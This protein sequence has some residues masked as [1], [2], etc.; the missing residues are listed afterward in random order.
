A[1]AV[2][3]RELL[4]GRDR[5]D[6]RRLSR[7]GDERAGARR[8]RHR[9]RDRADVRPCPTRRRS[10]RGRAAHRRSLAP[11]RADR[12]RLARG[13]ARGGRGDRP[14]ARGD[15]RA[16]DRS[17][18][19]VAGPG[20]MDVTEMTS[21]LPF[22]FIVGCGRSGTTMLRLMLD[23]HPEIAIPEESYFPMWPRR[24]IRVPGGGIDPDRFLESIARTDWFA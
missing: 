5:R 6:G 22:P 20:V 17:P 18:G 12:Q 8:D 4:P 1:R 11:R 2:R 15:L 24:E 23:S 14:G 19:K 9:R 10:A 3:P 7:G 21:H 16:P 13:G